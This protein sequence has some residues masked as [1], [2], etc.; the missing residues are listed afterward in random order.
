ME[1]KELMLD[2]SMFEPLDSSEKNNEFIAVE[3]KT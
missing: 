3:S 1:E 2:D